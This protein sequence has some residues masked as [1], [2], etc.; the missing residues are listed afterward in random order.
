[1][2]KDIQKEKEDRLKWDTQWVTST[3]QGRRFLWEFLSFCGIYHDIEGTDNQIFKQIGRRQ[4]GLHLLSLI[5]NASPEK[6]K[7]MMDEANQRDIEEKIKYD[8]T[9]RKHSNTELND[10]GGS[11]ATSSNDA[12][13]SDYLADLVGELPSYSDDTLGGGPIF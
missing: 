6:L 4:A 9:N 1:M 2:Q 7:Q 12:D 3:E 8:R 5:S 10:T 11:P 13:T